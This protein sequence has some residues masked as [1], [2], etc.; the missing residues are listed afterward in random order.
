MGNA[1][2]RPSKSL[3]VATVVMPLAAI[4]GHALMQ[5]ISTGP[6]EMALAVAVPSWFA[7]FDTATFSTFLGSLVAI[8][9]PVAAVP[10]F[11]SFTAESAASERNKLAI[12]TAI[13][14]LSASIIAAVFGQ[15]MLQFFS[16]SV[17]SLRIAGGIIVL[18][19]GLQLLQSEMSELASIDGTTTGANLRRSKIVSPLA[20]PFLLGPGAITAIIVQCESVSTTADAL[21]VGAVVTVVALLVMVTLLAAQPIAR[22]LGSSGLTVAA[23]I[24]GMI[25]AA[26]AI[27]MMITGIRNSFPG[28]A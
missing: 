24:G 21:T 18:L 5:G 13:A 23:R 3:R 19:M 1:M 26:I 28:I 11:L 8:V 14:V 2:Y 20:I 16:L 10:L 6:S 27:D 25:I 15:T 4:A 17:D 22:R 12:L 7:G 9:N